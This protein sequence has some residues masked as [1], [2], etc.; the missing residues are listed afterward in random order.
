MHL[1]GAPRRRRRL[2]GTPSGDLVVGQRRT[3]GQTRMNIL[4]RSVQK[5]DVDLADSLSGTA[6]GT[7]FSR[8]VGGMIAAV[9]VGSLGLRACITGHATLLGSRGSTL[10]LSGPAAVSF[11]VALLGLALF[12]HFH[13]VWTTS[14]LLYRWGDLGKGASLLV[15][16][17][18]L[19]YMG[20][21]IAM[22]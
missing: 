16:V 14:E 12:L 10:D 8:V 1:T 7:M 15:F 17:G 22:G 19:G 11:G 13:F 2:W 3:D 20:W 5:A 21:R 18:G 6:S 4:N 9:V